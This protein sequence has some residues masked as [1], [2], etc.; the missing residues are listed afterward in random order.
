MAAMT[1]ELLPIIAIIS[2]ASFITHY[3]ISLIINLHKA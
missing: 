3:N 2:E 1:F